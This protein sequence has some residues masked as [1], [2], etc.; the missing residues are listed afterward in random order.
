MKDLDSIDLS[1]LD[2]DQLEELRDSARRLLD[3]IAQHLEWWNTPPNAKLSPVKFREEGP[4]FYAEAVEDGVLIN[5]ALPADF[6]CTDNEQRSPEERARWWQ[7]PFIQVES[8][9]EQE[10][11]IRSHQ[12]YLRMRGNEELCRPDLEAYIQEQRSAW[13]AAWPEGKRYEARCLDGG[14]WDRSTGWGMFGTLAEA[15]AC[16]NAR[17]SE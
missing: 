5:P 2:A 13:F 16:I 3:G 7:R 6:D 1:T 4:I 9:E 15:L 11:L 17:C 10:R 8:W 14:A 12:E